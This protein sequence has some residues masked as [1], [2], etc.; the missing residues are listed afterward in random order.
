MALDFSEFTMPD[1]GEICSGYSGKVMY[2]GKEIGHIHNCNSNYPY[3][4][5]T[6]DRRWSTG[7]TGMKQAL[8]ELHMRS[9]MT[10]VQVN[11]ENL[12]PEEYWILRIAQIEML[13]DAD[14]T[15][16]PMIRCRLYFNS[17]N[18]TGS[19]TASKPALFS[20]ASIDPETFEITCDKKMPKDFVCF[21]N[22]KTMVAMIKEEMECLI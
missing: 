9:T 22:E 7:F 8:K 16:R 15:S 1:G 18:T 11:I 3:T 2:R 4:V 12:F 5:E 13:A 19:S 10:N 14:P 21:A 17:H 6:L 20:P